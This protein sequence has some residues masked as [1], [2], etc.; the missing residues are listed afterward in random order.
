MEGTRSEGR[1]RKTEYRRFPETQVR[2][3]M[4]LYIL[5]KT[6]SMPM[7]ARGG[8]RIVARQTNVRAAGEKK[9]KIL[10]SR[11]CVEV[12]DAFASESQV[13]VRCDDTRQRY[14]DRH[15]IFHRYDRMCRSQVWHREYARKPIEFL[16]PSIG[17]VAPTGWVHNGPLNTVAFFFSS[18][19][20]KSAG[21]RGRR[22]RM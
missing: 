3:E 16:A 8:R 18:S 6:E 2:N 11:K 15:I 4:M 21:G 5:Y 20:S 13:L 7:R 17:C 12:K 19:S 9:K 1:K 14:N 10:K 22:G